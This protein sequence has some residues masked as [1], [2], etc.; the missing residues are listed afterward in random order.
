MEPNILDLREHRCPM[1]L[2]LAKRHIL[3]LDHKQSTTILINDPS[4]VRDI[5]SYLQQQGFLS[6]CQPVADYFSVYVS[7]ESLPNV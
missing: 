1:T 7:K 2:L 6:K 4:S 5:Q 3:I